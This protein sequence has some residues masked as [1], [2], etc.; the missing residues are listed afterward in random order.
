MAE[1]GDLALIQIS[2]LIST[3]TATSPAP[4]TSAR[5]PGEDPPVSGRGM[6]SSNAQG[7]APDQ[8]LSLIFTFW[9]SF[10]FTEKLQRQ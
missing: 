6:G 10:R 2:N 8:S 4:H 5:S 3:Q 9:N 1:V 7:Q